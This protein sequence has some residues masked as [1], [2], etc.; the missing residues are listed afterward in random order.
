MERPYRTLEERNDFKAKNLLNHN[1]VQKIRRV[2][3]IFYPVKKNI[4]KSCHVKTLTMPVRIP[5]ANSHFSEINTTNV[6]KPE[7]MN[8]NKAL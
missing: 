4:T 6:V 8:V 3:L 1:F 2:W 7:Y 5:G